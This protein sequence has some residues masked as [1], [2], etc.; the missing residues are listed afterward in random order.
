MS[1]TYSL[2]NTQIESLFKVATTAA[3]KIDNDD[4]N[5]E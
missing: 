4:D 1:I 3:E 2:I 5:K